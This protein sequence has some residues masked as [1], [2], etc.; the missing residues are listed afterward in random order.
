[1]GELAELY[2]DSRPQL[3]NLVEDTAAPA[4]HEGEG[5][6]APRYFYMRRVHSLEGVAYCV[7]S[8]YLDERIFQRAPARVRSELVI[9][10][11][12][13]R[14]LTPRAY[15]HLGAVPPDEA[16]DLPLFGQ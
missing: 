12:R 16:Q 7:I 2:R 13:G 3:L 5:I 4:L 11:P 9:R 15:D 10:T 6:A 14:K 8:I 1:M